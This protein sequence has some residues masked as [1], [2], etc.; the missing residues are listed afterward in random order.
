MITRVDG[1]ERRIPIIRLDGRDYFV[2]GGTYQR[3]HNERIIKEQYTPA[4]EGDR[5]VKATSWKR[6]KMTLIVPQSTSQINSSG[7]GFTFGDINSIHNTLKK[8][9]PD[10]GLEYYDISALENFGGTY[11][12]YVYAKNDWET[13]HNNDPGIWEVPVQIW[14][15]NS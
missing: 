2:L 4:G 10:N 13:P 6:W 9:Y 12:H 7:S 5:Q 3:L 8:Q 15:R 14:G 1:I 11:T